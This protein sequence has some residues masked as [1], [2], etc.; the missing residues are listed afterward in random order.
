[1]TCLFTYK[2]LLSRKVILHHKNL[3]LFARNMNMRPPK[4][5]KSVTVQ[6]PENGV[7]SIQVTA[8]YKGNQVENEVV[9]VTLTENGQSHTFAEKTEDMGTWTA[10][11]PILLIKGQLGEGKE[12]EAKPE[13]HCSGVVAHMKFSLHHEP[14]HIHFME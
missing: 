5:T 3:I 2:I 8:V 7:T 1:M 6:A 4:Y 9:T 10:V 14:E 11:R 13:D 12:F